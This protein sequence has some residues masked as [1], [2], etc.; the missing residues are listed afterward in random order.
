MT[1]TSRTILATLVAAAL[2]GLAG[3]GQDDPATAGGAAATADATTAPPAARSYPAGVFEHRE[4][5]GLKAGGQCALDRINKEKVGALP[6]VVGD[7][8]LFA[9]WFLPPKGVATAQP[10]LVLSDGTRQF[11][12]EIRTGG[13]RDDVA[14]RLDRP[15]AATSGY[16]ARVTLAGLPAGEY[17]VWFVQEGEG[18]FRCDTKKTITVTG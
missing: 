15:E 5:A 1:P 3:C 16:N 18:A 7:T 12:H 2:A 4:A 8:L 14:R 6:Y 10:L 17:A 13:R 11:A 9:G